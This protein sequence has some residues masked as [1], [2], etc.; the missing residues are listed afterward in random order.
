VAGRW[1]GCTCEGD[2]V[3]THKEVVVHQSN[4]ALRGGEGLLEAVVQ[5][6]VVLVS[7]F[8]E[9][10]ERGGCGDP[11]GCRGKPRGV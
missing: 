2:D 3:E 7:W 1:G 10:D 5:R 4:D 6:R 11:S 8:V 9:C